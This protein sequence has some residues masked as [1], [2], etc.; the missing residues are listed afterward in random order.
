M[1]TLGGRIT[2]TGI[3]VRGR[4]W[5]IRVT[6][7]L[8]QKRSEASTEQLV[9]LAWAHIHGIEDRTRKIPRPPLPGNAQSDPD[10]SIDEGILR[11]SI[12]PGEV[13][14]RV[15]GP[16]ISR[17]A[18]ADVEIVC[19]QIVEPGAAEIVRLPLAAPLRRGDLVAF[20]ES[21][22]ARSIQNDGTAHGVVM[23]CGRQNA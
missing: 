1:S 23:R 15:E 19:G 9:L 14:I 10:Y 20:D 7:L 8:D 12:G 5:P 18:V 4:R 6:A 11:C 22:D 21:L 16:F 13:P 2:V 3:E 17:P